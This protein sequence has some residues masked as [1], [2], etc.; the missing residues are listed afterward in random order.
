L[1]DFTFLAG[2][3]QVVADG[4]TGVLGDAELAQ[5]LVVQVD[6][7][8]SRGLGR[9]GKDLPG[10]RRPPLPNGAAVVGIGG[11]GIAVRHLQENP[12][13][14]VGAKA[15]DLPF[16]GDDRGHDGGGAGRRAGR[17]GPTM[18]GQGAGGPG[19]SGSIGP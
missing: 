19:T 16:G 7:R 5:G 9:G 4:K 6:S 1:L 15:G 11:T 2:Q 10:L 3:V 12:G 8:R 13:I 18:D 17:W 14:A